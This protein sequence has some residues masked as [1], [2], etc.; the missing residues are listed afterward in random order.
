MSP[1]ITSRISAA[2]V[3]GLA[4]SF[5]VHHMEVKRGEMGKSAFETSQSERFDK[6]YAKP[7][8]PTAPV[9]LFAALLVAG[10]N[11]GVYELLAFGIYTVVKPK[12]SPGGP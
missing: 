3:M 5:A 10:L 4:L 6:F 8:N 7:R 1:R 12:P 11:F 9:S 2:I